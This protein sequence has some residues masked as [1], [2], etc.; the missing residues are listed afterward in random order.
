MPQTVELLFF[1]LGSGSGASQSE[2]H[3]TDLTCR[4]ISKGIKFTLYFEF[5][6]DRLY[7]YTN[8][9]YKKSGCKDLPSD[10]S[11]NFS[12]FF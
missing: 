8:M 4:P 2:G 7:E 10:Y 1:A 5:T 12:P 11:R 9:Q 3:M 6:F